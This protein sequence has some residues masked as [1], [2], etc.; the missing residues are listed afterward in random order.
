MRCHVGQGVRATRRLSV[1]AGL[2]AG[3]RTQSLSYDVPQISLLVSINRAPVSTVSITVH[4]PHIGQNDY[5]QEMRIAGTA[6]EASRWES[7]TTMVC[8]NGAGVGGTKRLA[9]TVGELVG[10]GTISFSFDSPSLSNLRRANKPVTGS[11]SITVQGQNFATAGY[12]GRITS[13]HT[14]Q[15]TTNW[16]SDTSLRCQAAHG[17]KATRRI[18][19]TVGVQIGTVTQAMSNDLPGLS[20]KR[21]TNRPGTGSTS[22]TVHA[23]SFGHL[24]YTQQGIQGHTQCEATDWESETS[25]RCLIGQGIQGTRRVSVTVG[26][27]VGSVTAAYSTDLGR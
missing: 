27:R 1:T 19:V 25:M 21:R 14:S 2:R 24:Q 13:G 10:S 16:E 26:E 22:V 8:L 12:T 9:L 5:T 17:T 15:E 4:G 3:S 7:E 6:C 20:T 23:S 18:S 11:V